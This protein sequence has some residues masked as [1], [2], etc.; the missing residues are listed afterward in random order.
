[1]SEL[2]QLAKDFSIPVNDYAN[3][4]NAILGIRGAG[5]TYTAM[6]AAEELLENSIPIVVYDPIGVWKNLKVGVGKHSGFPIV[7]AG[8]EGSD[9]ILTKD[10]AVDIIRAAMKEKISIIFDLYSPEL[11]NKST[12][13]KIV[14]E[15]VDVLMNENKPFGL[16]H[17]FL[18]EAAEFIPQRL[19]P[20]HSRVYSSLERM[21]RMGRNAGL[22][23]TLINQRAEEV[24]KAILEICECT[25]LHKQVGKNSLK[26]I[27]QWFDYRQIE[28][29][30]RII[31]SLP[32]LEQGECWVIGIGDKPELIKIAPRK[33]FHPDP[34][35]SKQNHRGEM[36]VDVSGFVS[37]MNL[38]LI[39]SKEKVPPGKFENVDHD[40]YKFKNEITQLKQEIDL[41]KAANSEL[42][43]QVRALQSKMKDYSFRMNKIRDL[44]D[45]ASIVTD[46]IKDIAIKFDVPAL[47]VAPIKKAGSTPVHKVVKNIGDGTYS[48]GKCAG[49]IASFLATYPERS[50]SKVQVA[51]AAGYAVGS[52]NFNNALAELNTRG[53]LIRDGGKLQINL[54]ADLSLLPS[55]EVKIHPSLTFAEKL[56]KCEKEIYEVLMKHPKHQFSKDQV[57]NLTPSIYAPNSGSFNNALARLNTLELIKRE[58][59]LIRLNPELLE[60]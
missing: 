23:L 55:Y 24:N 16:R 15:T 19:Q 4:G 13:I 43:Q 21:A 30:A 52:G 45:D 46:P 47:V 42:Q 5:K 37:K 29:V 6:K 18:E 27:Q 48:P 26:S 8:G 53:Y 41:H 25:L 51:I 60:I 54:G 10:N 56:G 9:I 17:V 38:Q 49:A 1:M 50:F 40:I 34:K 20:Q 2:I 3:Q 35:Q 7:V 57:A 39:N 12:W 58:S 28:N 22:G 44:V 14:Q 36:T 59:G 33:T 31:R 32:A 11:S